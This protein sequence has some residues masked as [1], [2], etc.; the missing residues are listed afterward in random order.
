MKLEQIFECFNLNERVKVKL[1]T[2]E[3]SGYALIWWSQE[4]EEVYSG[5][6]GQIEGRLKEEKSTIGDGGVFNEGQ[7]EESQEATMARFFHGLNRE[8]QDIV[9]LHHYHS[10][11]DLIHKATMR[12]ITSRSPYPSSTWK[13]KEKDKPK[14]NKDPKKESETL[15][16]Q[17]EVKA[18]PTLVLLN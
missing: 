6:I 2:L 14:K 17:N 9:E 5:D 7:V 16:V 8:I 4:D 13:D 1:V 3:F 11:E 10:L 15:S 12:K 18:P